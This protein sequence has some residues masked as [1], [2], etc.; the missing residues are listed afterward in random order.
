MLNVHLK[1]LPKNIPSI[2]TAPLSIVL[3]YKRLTDLYSGYS[4]V[5]AFLTIFHPMTP[6]RKDIRGDRILKKQKGA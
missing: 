3:S 4:S 2:Q 1:V 5:A 6:M